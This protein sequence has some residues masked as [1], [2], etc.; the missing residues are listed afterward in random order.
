MALTCTQLTAISIARCGT[1]FN[2]NLWVPPCSNLA[3]RG[4]FVGRASTDRA[5]LH[6][7]ARE[8]TQEKEEEGMS[9]ISVDLGIFE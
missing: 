8:E 6:N 2:T 4:N 7:L 5:L 3:L 9:D 1:H